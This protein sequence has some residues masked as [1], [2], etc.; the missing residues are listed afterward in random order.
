[1]QRVRW[2]DAGQCFLSLKR[3]HDALSTC[4]GNL[5]RRGRIMPGNSGIG[6]LCAMQAA[7][8]RHLEEDGSN[9]K[10]VGMSGRLYGGRAGWGILVVFAI[11]AGRTMSTATVLA[12]RSSLLPEQLKC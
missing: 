8:T 2:G 3:A 1:M 9:L 11:G 6:H 12:Y 10:E 4:E 5:V 7:M